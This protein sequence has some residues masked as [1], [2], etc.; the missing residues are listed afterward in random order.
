MR[1]I[2]T[3]CL[4][5]AVTAGIAQSDSSKRWG[6]GINGG[7]CN[8]QTFSSDVLARC[9]EMFKGYIASLFF[10]HPDWRKFPNL[11]FSFFVVMKRIFFLISFALVPTSC[12]PPIILYSIVEDTPCYQQ[13]SIDMNI[14]LG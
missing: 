14:K 8:N 9:S 2:I 11:R 12:Y 3:I 1:I 5:L 7:Y 4:L 6:I 13:D 10:E